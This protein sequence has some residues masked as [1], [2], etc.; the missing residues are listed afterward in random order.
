MIM[1][2]RY[3]PSQ[4]GASLAFW[5]EGE[6]DAVVMTNGY[7]NSTLYWGPLR[8]E[9]RKNYRVIRWDLR[10]HGES[11]PARDLATM[12]IPGCADDLRRVMDAAGV[13]RAVLAGFSLGCQI[14]LEA[15]RHFPER[16]AGIIPIL[17][18]YER[19]FD[20]LIHPRLGP[21]VFAF[22]KGAGPEVWGPALK[23]GALALRQRPMHAIAKATGMVGVDLSAKKMEPFYR[24]LARI[25]IPTW[26]AL[27][28]DAQRHSA[29]DLLPQISVPT[30]VIAGGS[31]RFSPGELGREMATMIPG[32]EL[33]WIEEATH[34]GL[35]DTAEPI[36]E[37]VERFL[38]RVF[39]ENTADS[40]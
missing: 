29:R 30:L 28:L 35:F 10:G 18:P 25:D 17:G 4:D 7:A 14:V 9:L 21:L 26:F 27:G 32:A 11:G 23:V 12:T 40:A 15:W 37:A 39:K 34:T 19:P 1:R 38:P 16:I 6:G 5:D 22:Y 24:H 13:E 20:T 2:T 31:D 8:D 36:I 33:V 3:I